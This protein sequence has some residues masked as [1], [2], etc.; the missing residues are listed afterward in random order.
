MTIR[1]PFGKYRGVRVEDLEASYC[2][3]LLGR[4]TGDMAASL[5]AALEDRVRQK[6]EEVSRG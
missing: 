5:R 3:H 4:W 1:M 6:A 2:E